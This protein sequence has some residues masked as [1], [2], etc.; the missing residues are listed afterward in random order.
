MQDQVCAHF[1]PINETCT[2]CHFL[3]HSSRGLAITASLHSHVHPKLTFPHSL[4]NQCVS[5]RPIG[6][7]VMVWAPSITLR[8]L[9]H[10]PSIVARLRRQCTPPRISHPS[11]MV[12][13]S[14]FLSRMD[15]E[16][17]KNRTSTTHHPMTRTIVRCHRGSQR[18]KNR[19]SATKQNRKWRRKK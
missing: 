12:S 14:R 11:S 6:R 5:S 18:K 10:S 16:P 4:H 13:I 7:A 17:G 15:M 8:L 3:V 1:M 2:P 9:L 19:N